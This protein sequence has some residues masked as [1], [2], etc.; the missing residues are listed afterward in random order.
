MKHM[1]CP[2]YDEVE[3][4]ATRCPERA[5]TFLDA[6][7]EYGALNHNRMKRIFITMR[8]YPHDDDRCAQRVREIGEDINRMG[9]LQAMQGCYYVFI[10]AIRIM[11]EKVQ[12]TENVMEDLHSIVYSL[13]C[14]WD[15]VGGWRN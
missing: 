10:A 12:K 14:L 8:V 5:Y 13:N 6:W 4:W 3:D 11:L 2:S 7:S 9:G 1:Q 15:G